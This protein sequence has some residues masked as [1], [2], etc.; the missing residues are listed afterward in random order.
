[1]KATQPILLMIPHFLSSR[2]ACI[3]MRNFGGLLVSLTLFIVI[4]ASGEPFPLPTS[5]PLTNV[6]FVAF[7]TETTGLS[8]E[9]GFLLEIAAVRFRLDGVLARQCWLINPGV[10]IPEAARRVNNI[11]DAMVSNSPPVATVLPQFVHFAEGSV[12]L[13]HNARF[14]RGFV[15]TEANRHSL[16]LPTGPL[17]DSL[18]LFKTWFPGP[19]SYNLEALTTS[20]LPGFTNQ[21]PPVAIDGRTN[22]FHTALWDSECLAALFVRGTTNL[23]P[24]ATLADLLRVSR[25]AYSFRNPKRLWRPSGNAQSSSEAAPDELAP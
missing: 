14:D 13:A 8:A 5:T 4:D 9:T 25:G 16:A 10:P 22:Q 7:D 17:F 21:V 23:P 11:T 12:L 20:L 24:K 3:G 18:P 19:R 2:L 6:T 15:A 1:M